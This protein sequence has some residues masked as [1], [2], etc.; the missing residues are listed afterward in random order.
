[1]EEV[2]R[3]NTT[4]ILFSKTILFKVLKINLFKDTFPFLERG[5]DKDM[6]FNC[7]ICTKSENLIVSSTVNFFKLLSRREV[8]Q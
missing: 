5:G 4:C 6:R 3:I 7:D 1:M 2:Q 8:G